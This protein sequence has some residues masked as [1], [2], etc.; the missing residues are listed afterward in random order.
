MN[1]GDGSIPSS[2]RSPST[3]MSCSRPSRA[4]S[5]RAPWPILASGGVV[6][7]QMTGTRQHAGGAGDYDYR[8]TVSSARPATDLTA[9]IRAS[10][11]HL[12]QQPE[13][14]WMLWQR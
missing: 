2:G 3:R 13:A 11:D 4:K 5:W 10:R 7:K 8:A 12:A 1:C 9:R 6:E 14:G